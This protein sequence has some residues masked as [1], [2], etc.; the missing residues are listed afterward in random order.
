MTTHDNLPQN[1]REMFR[2][3][4]TT[5]Y[6][7]DKTLQSEDVDLPYCLYLVI[8]THRIII[9]VV[10]PLGGDI[11]ASSVQLLVPV[12][13]KRSLVYQWK[14]PNCCLSAEARS[15]EVKT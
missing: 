15:Y 11:P 8:L 12:V 7:N 9:P 3:A 14:H 4:R 2:A 10:S 1:E 13:L 5:V 6:G